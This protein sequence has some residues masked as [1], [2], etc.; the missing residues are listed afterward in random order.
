MVI[1]GIG[2]YIKKVS[3]KHSAVPESKKVLKKQKQ[4]N[5]T[6]IGV[7]QR[8]ACRSQLKELQRPQLKQC[9]QQN[10]VVLDYKHK[11]NIHQSTRI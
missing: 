7:R 2:Q 4:K 11:I 3:L 1:L 6:M 9:E 8:D 10:E 5:P